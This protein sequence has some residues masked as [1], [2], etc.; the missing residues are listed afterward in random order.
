M[1]AL[2]SRYFLN[3]SKGET[4][5]HDPRVYWCV[6]KVCK[7]LGG[8]S[9]ESKGGHAFMKETMRKVGGI[10]GAENSAQPFFQRFFLL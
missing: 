5:Y 8:I 7:E 1:V 2:L 9:V 6:Q 3:R 4:I 10:Y